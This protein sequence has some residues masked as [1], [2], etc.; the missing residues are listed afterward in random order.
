[1]KE[2]EHSKPKVSKR[3]KKKAAAKEEMVFLEKENGMLKEEIHILRELIQEAVPL[4]SKMG[5]NNSD[6]TNSLPTDEQASSQMNTSPDKNYFS[7]AKTLQEIPEVSKSELYGSSHMGNQA[8]IFP[9]GDSI[10][11]IDPSISQLPV[12]HTEDYK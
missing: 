8:A 12:E 7:G 3:S 1:L 2:N 10:S 11:G 9:E 4:F 5:N 6:K